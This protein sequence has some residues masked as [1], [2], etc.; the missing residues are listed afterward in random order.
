MK[1]VLLSIISFLSFTYLI[2]SAEENWKLEK[3]KDGIKVWTRKAPNTSLKEYKVSTI[4]NTTPEKL[5]SFFRNVKEYDKWNFKAEP[6]STKIIKKISD[7]DFY[8]Y[9]IISAPLIKSREA[10]SRMTFKQPDANGVILINFE[11]A[12]NVIPP[13]PDYIRIPSMK[14]YFKIVPMENGKV[15]LIHQALSSPGGTIPDVLVNMGAVDAPFYM[16]SKI[17]ELLH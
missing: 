1:R 8:T 4:L 3:N 2:A 12:P 16:F 14:A 13:N 11:G 6:G 15:E 7:D 5:L 9:M 10:V 17:K